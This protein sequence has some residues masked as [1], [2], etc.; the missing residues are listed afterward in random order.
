MITSTIFPWQAISRRFSI[1]HDAVQAGIRFIE[2][3]QVRAG[4]KLRGDGQA[5]FLAAGK[6]ADQRILPAGKAEGFQRHPD[7]ALFFF[8]RH[9]GGQPQVRRVGDRHEHGILFPHQV[10]LRDETDPVL[11]LVILGIV[12]HAALGDGGLRL[13]ISGHRVDEGAL[14]GAGAAQDHD[15][16]SRLHGQVDILQQGDFL[17][18]GGD[19]PFVD[20]DVQAALQAVQPVEQAGSFEEKAVG[21]DL[22]AVVK[23]QRGVFCG[24]AA[25]QRQVRHADLLQEPPA[26]FIFQ[27][28]GGRFLLF[29]RVLD[30]HGVSVVVHVDHLPVG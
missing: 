16:V 26:V 10:F 30:H 8:R 28:Q 21:P 25:V 13:F 9:V 2:D 11:D 24:Q 3:E 6:L 7:P 1:S 18:R 14:A 22:Q 27:G 4:H 19:G 23:L 15:H 20:G 29:S 17:R 5:L 12:V